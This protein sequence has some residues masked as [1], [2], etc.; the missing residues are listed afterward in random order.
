MC[1]I[2]LEEKQEQRNKIMCEDETLNDGNPLQEATYAE[3]PF[4]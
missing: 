4:F 3:F 1:I 2:C